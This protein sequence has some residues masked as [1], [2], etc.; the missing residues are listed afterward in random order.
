MEHAKF[1]FRFN[2]NMLP[3]YF[4][5]YFVK[6]ETIH[7]YHTH[8]KPKKIFFH[9]F[10]HTEWGRKIIHRKG[11]NAWKKIAFRIKKLLISKIQSNVQKEYYP[12]LYK[13]LFMFFSQN[14]KIALSFVALLQLF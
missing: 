11:L 4:K 7:R 13:Y 9:T 12:N 8:Q 2:I 6:L 3:D 10:A 5:N 1:L 14:N